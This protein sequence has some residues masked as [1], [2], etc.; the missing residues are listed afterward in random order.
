MQ[1]R[2][3]ILSIDKIS[4]R[5]RVFAY[6]QLRPCICLSI[7]QSQNQPSASFNDCNAY[8]I[9]ALYVLLLLLYFI[10]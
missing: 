1:V 7:G 10:I 3:E 8:C 6:T 9:Y 5:I 2:V 4:I